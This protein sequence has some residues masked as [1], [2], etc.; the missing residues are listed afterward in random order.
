[1]AK[2]YVVQQPMRRVSE[3]DVDR[4]YYGAKALGTFVPTFDMTPALEYGDIELLL[5]SGVF[6]GIATV[7]MIRS[8]HEKLRDFSDDDF[9]ILTGNPV[10]MGIACAVAAHYNAGAVNILQ[11]DRRQRKYIKTANKVW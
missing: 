9:L 1:M 11:W 5:D 8:F 10:A 4:G 7:P 3:D 2:V 6:V